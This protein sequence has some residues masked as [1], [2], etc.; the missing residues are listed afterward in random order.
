MGHKHLREIHFTVRYNKKQQNA[1]I[2][3]QLKMLQTKDTPKYFMANGK[4]RYKKLSTR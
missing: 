3:K 1:D 4:G 2:A